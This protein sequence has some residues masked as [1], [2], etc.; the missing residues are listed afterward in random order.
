MR[1]SSRLSKT[2]VR[3]LAQDER[4][5]REFI[6]HFLDANFQAKD[7]RTH[8]YGPA[9]DHVRLDHVIAPRTLKLAKEGQETW[10]L[11]LCQIQ[12]LQNAVDEVK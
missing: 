11:G 12:E 1:R 9:H 5:A 4:Q 2:L 10:I 3:A 8:M 7:R 6:T